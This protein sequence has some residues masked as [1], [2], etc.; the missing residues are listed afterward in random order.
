MIAEGGSSATALREGAFLLDTNLTLVLAAFFQQA[1]KSVSK[2]WAIFCR[3]CSKSMEEAGAVKVY[4]D[5]F[6]R[7]FRGEYAERAGLFVERFVEAEA[8]L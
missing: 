5:S 1:L 7:I 4:L 2:V 8:L 3:S 6:E